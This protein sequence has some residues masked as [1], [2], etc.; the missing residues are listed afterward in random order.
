MRLRLN[1]TKTELIW[2]HRNNHPAHP[3]NNQCLQLDPNCIITPVNTVRDLGVLLYS[4]LNL[5]AHIT[6]VT[7]SCFFHL[8]RIRQTVAVY[9]SQ[10]MSEWTL[11]ASPGSNSRYIKD[12]LLQLNS[13]QSASSNNS[14]VDH[15]SPCRCSD[16]KRHPS[17]RS[18]HTRYAKSTLASHPGESNVQTLFAHVQYLLAS[19]SHLYVL[20]DQRALK[21]DRKS[22]TSINIPRW[23]GGS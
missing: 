12:W 1:P 11:P 13:R 16:Y 21:S 18:H 14:S 2:F 8:R 17:S 10:E 7:R 5:R 6:S 9:D 3:L 15:R 19:R 20:I 4:S 22:W 23:C